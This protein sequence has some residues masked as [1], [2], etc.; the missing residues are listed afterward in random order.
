MSQISQICVYNP[1]A[2]Q[3]LATQL[4]TVE[5][6][7][8]HEFASIAAK[9]AAEEMDEY[10]PFV[11]SVNRRVLPESEMAEQRSVPSTRDSTQL[12]LQDSGGE[13]PAGIGTPNRKVVPKAIAVVS[14]RASVGDINSEEDSPAVDRNIPFLRMTSPGSI[15][16]RKANVYMR[17]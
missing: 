8:R 14:P 12:A 1:A 6:P 11:P 17:R 10:E 7:V 13:L 15:A 5:G 9:I 3:G 4:K 2:A 16:P